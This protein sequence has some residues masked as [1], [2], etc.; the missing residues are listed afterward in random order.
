MSLR[1]VP[2]LADW[3]PR[4]NAFVAEVRERPH[5]YGEHDCLLFIG[6]A[7]EALTGED[8]WREHVG[9][10]SDKAGARAYLRS[11]GHVS[12]GRYLD[13]LFRTIPAAFAQRGDVVISHRIPGLYMA[14]TALFVG[15]GGLLEK[16]REMWTR[17]H[18]WAVGR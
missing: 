12:P 2:R 7:V 9:R 10:Y 8:L 14:G 3:E 6:G 18:A 4:L 15:D 17:T 5:V 13:S 1:T 11:L 16:P